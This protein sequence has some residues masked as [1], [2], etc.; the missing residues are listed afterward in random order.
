VRRALELATGEGIGLYRDLLDHL[1]RLPGLDGP[2]MH[3]LAERVGG[4]SDNERLELFFSLLLGLLE[5]MIRTGA[6]G[7]GV[8]GEE[9]AL[10]G[11]LLDSTDLPRW[12]EAWEAIGQAK[13]DASALNL[14]RNLLVLE[15]F[16]R[17]Q[18][19]ARGTAA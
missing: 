2:G 14:D 1:G 12:V 16:Y 8:I 7:E 11:R 5:R 10:A 13:A 19:V 9:N 15:T 18:Q 4:Y 6:T 3:R 17:L